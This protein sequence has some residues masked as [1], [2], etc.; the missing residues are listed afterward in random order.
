MEAVDPDARSVPRGDR[1]RSLNLWA[2]ALHLAQ[3]VAILVLSTEFALPVMSFFL[4]FEEGRTPALQPDPQ[5]LFDLRIGPMVAAFLFL[6]AFAHVV[7]A[8]PLGYPR[9]RADLARGMNRA[10]WIEYSVSS[11]VMIVIVAMLVGI[12]DVAALLLIA[13]V[14]ACM[15]LFGWAMEVLNQTTE[16]TN[17]LSYWFGVFAGAMPWVAIAIYLAGAGGGENGP[18]TFVYFIFVSIFLFFN[19]FAINMLLQYRKVGPWSDYL[20]GE[21]AYIVLSLTAKSLLA[22][23]VFAGTLRPE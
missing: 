5:V 18:P 4:G 14:N 15:I 17:W 6:S 3:G 22:W 1:L 7:I 13:A 23:Q 2:G 21:R 8:S 10:R 9:Y 19:V 16:R 11:S 20:Y 12:Y